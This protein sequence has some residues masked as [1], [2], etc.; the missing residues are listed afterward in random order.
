[1]SENPPLMRWVFLWRGQK[2]IT[3]AVRCRREPGVIIHIELRMAVF[4]LT[5]NHQDV[6]IKTRIRRVDISKTETS[7]FTRRLITLPE[8]GKI[9]VADGHRFLLP[10]RASVSAGPSLTHYAT[11]PSGDEGKCLTTRA[12]AKSSRD[13]KPPEICPTAQAI[14]TTVRPDAFCSAQSANPSC[15]SSRLNQS[16]N[17]L[18]FCLRWLACGS[19]IWCA[20]SGSAHASPNT[21]TRIPSLR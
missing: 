13:K 15:C 19:T 5:D 6:F 2:G 14:V 9:I 21:G 11:F 4:A 8:G 17:R 20:L 3:A 16:R 12:C 18:T 7:F 10:G 1:M